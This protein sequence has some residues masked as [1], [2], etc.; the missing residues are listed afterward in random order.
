MRHFI[1][2]SRTAHPSAIIAARARKLEVIALVQAKK[3]SFGHGEELLHKLTTLRMMKTAQAAV[4]NR[5]VKRVQQAHLSFITI[6]APPKKEQIVRMKEVEVSDASAWRGG[7]NKNPMDIEEKMVSLLQAQLAEYHL[8]LAA[9]SD[10]H[11]SLFT[12]IAHKEGDLVCSLPAL[13][14]DAIAKLEEFLS[15]AGNKYLSSRLAKISG[16]YL[17]EEDTASDVYAVLVGAARYLRHF[18]GLRKGGPN[19][20][21]VVNPSAGA[22]DDFLS[23]VTSTRNN[24]GIAAR[25]IVV[26]NFGVD[27]SEAE[28]VDFDEPDVKKFKGML[29]RFLVSR[30]EGEGGL[31]PVDA[32]EDAQPMVE[33]PKD[34]K[35]KDEKEGAHKKDD[36]DEKAKEE[37]QEKPKEEKQEKPKKE[38][39]QQQQKP[40]ASSSQ[41]QASAAASSKPTLRAVARNRVL[42]DGT[43]LG[44][45]DMEDTKGIS[46]VRASDGSLKVVPPES[47]ESNKK[48]P[49]KRVLW[50]ASEG[51]VD[52]SPGPVVWSFGKKSRNTLVLYQ[53]AVMTIADAIQKS[54]ASSIAKHQPAK[55]FPGTW[56]D[57]LVPPE[58]VCFVPKDQKVSDVLK[59]IQDVASLQTVWCVKK[60]NENSLVPTGVAVINAK[61]L[62]MSTGCGITCT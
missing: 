2:L 32:K 14:F 22:S 57:R 25:G 51:K 36:K 58:G 49:P 43:I 12:E 52:V 5:G 28:N 8:Y 40:A 46:F 60:N 61:Q 31:S 20:A 1:A 13:L 7:F 30:G 35:P 9:A 39:E 27:Y 33:K 6:A 45:F 59:A 54:G 16:C 53:K 62:I 4:G 48:I 11:M 37:K 3:H 34:E 47:Q 44:T 41:Q 23:V 15:T 24:V 10:G 42:A 19:V 17:T 50:H 29:D 56:T 55:F 18:L 38:D 21:I 26:A